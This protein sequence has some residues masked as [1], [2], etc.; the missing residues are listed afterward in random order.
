MAEPK[1]RHQAEAEGAQMV[2][3]AKCAQTG[4]KRC[5]VYKRD[6][7][8][9]NNW[10]TVPIILVEMGYMT[11]DKEDENLNDPDYQALLVRGMVNGIEE[12][13]NR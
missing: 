6:T 9:M 7:Y 2:V 11:N 4:V 10:S 13:F 3:N 12:Y 5:G 1:K 8:T